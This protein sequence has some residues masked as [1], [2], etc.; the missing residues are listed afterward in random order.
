MKKNV[1]IMIV[2]IITIICIMLCH[3]VEYYEFISPIFRYLFAEY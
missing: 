2:R 1:V 3:T